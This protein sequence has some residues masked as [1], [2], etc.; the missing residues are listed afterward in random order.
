[1]SMLGTSGSGGLGADSAAADRLLIAG[2]RLEAV[3]LS[4]GTPVF[5]TKDEVGI[6]RGAYNGKMFFRKGDD[7]TAFDAATRS[8]ERRVGKECV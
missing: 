2:E 5:K 1:M 3:K 6:L 8:E 7:V 4:D